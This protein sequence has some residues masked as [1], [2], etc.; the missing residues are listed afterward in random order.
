MEKR[1]INNQLTA[2]SEIQKKYPDTFVLLKDVVSNGA[3]IVEG[4]MI[5][6]N[7]NQDKVWAKL[8]ELR[9]T[10]GKNTVTSIEY[11]GGKLDEKEYI[12]IL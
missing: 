5:Y 2:F 8:R 1:D 10:L 6:K 4:V 9:G 12:F 3:K 7:K 11:T